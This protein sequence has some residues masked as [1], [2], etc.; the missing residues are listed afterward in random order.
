MDRRPLLGAQVGA[1]G[2]ARR[3]LVVLVSLLFLMGCSAADARSSD[4]PV[5]TYEAAL[6]PLKKR[7]DVLEKQFAAV[8][9]KGYRGP[10]QVIDVLAE[11][12]PKYA[13][14]LD[15]TRAIKPETPELVKA[16]KVLIQSLLL[17]QQGL[18]LALQGMRQGDSAKVARAGR[19]L[20]QAQSLV[21]EHRRLVAAARQ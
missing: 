21:D 3:I 13:E 5:A 4:D 19:A 11:I 1:A 6:A 18:T 17:Q 9:G 14:L 20:E 7:S 2:G 12:I 10:Q 16:H 15:E 8:Q